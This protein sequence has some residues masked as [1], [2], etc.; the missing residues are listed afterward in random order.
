[1][2]LVIAAL[3]AA[4]LLSLYDS[5]V[6]GPGWA[7]I[8]LAG[9]LATGATYLLEAERWWLEGLAA[10]FLAVVAVAAHQWVLVQ[11]DRGMMAAMARR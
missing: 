3:A 6:T 9:L 2:T 8:I 4:L 5:T 11:R 10:G 7:R 1:M